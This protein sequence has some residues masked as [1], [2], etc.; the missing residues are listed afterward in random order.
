MRFLIVDDS[1]T[2][3]MLLSALI[4]RAVADAEIETVASV[5]S[6]VALL[7][8]DTAPFEVV[9]LDMKLPDG[10]GEQLAQPLK[11]HSPN[12]QITLVSGLNPKMLAELSADLD[13]DDFLQKPLDLVTVRQRVAEI[14][15]LVAEA[16]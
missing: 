15:R 10:D 1:E 5:A 14:T 13:F 11:A 8:G 16:K 7:S 4:Q 3:Q 6:G 2:D 9:F 12:A